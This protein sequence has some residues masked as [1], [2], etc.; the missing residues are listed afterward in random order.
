MECP[1]PY[2]TLN[3]LHDNA[4]LW[5]LPQQITFVKRYFSG[6]LF[7]E[8]KAEKR[9]LCKWLLPKPTIYFTVSFKQ[10]LMFKHSLRA[11]R[12]TS[13]QFCQLLRQLEYTQG[14]ILF[15]F[16]VIQHEA[17]KLWNPF[18]HFSASLG[19]FCET[20]HC[21]FPNNIF[22]K[23]SYWHTEGKI[24]SQRQYWQI[25]KRKG[26]LR[27]KFWVQISPGI[28]EGTLWNC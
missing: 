17:K 25:I 6:Q 7:N 20:I 24:S 15:G 13:N 14:Q 9:L 28:P 22:T 10:E 23:V 26:R 19:C 2:N 11:Q 8:S 4:V 1:N 16:R 27:V 21:S 5:P 18:L 3:N 12:Q